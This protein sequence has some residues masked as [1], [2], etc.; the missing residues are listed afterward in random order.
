MSTG[1]TIR[2][3]RRMA[4]RPQYDVSRSIGRSPSWLCMVEK[5]VLTPKPADLAKLKAEL[6]ISDEELK[7]K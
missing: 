1:K 4:D 6:G 7:G 2:N 3:R 5:D